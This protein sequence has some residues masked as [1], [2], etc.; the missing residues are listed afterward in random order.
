[1]WQQPQSVIKALDDHYFDY[2]GI[3]PW[4]PPITPTQITR[5]GGTTVGRTV[6]PT[7]ATTLTRLGTTRPRRTTIG[8]TTGTTFTTKVTKT[9]AGRLIIITDLHGDMPVFERTLELVAFKKGTLLGPNDLVIFT[10]DMVDRGPDAR[11]IYQ[12]LKSLKNKYK[13]RMTILIGNHELMN[14]G[15]INANK[16]KPGMPP[17]WISDAQLDC[18]AEFEGD[19]D[20]REAEWTSN[21]EIGKFVRTWDAIKI[22]ELPGQPE[23]RPLVMHGGLP[24]SMF[25]EYGGDE[26]AIKKLNDA[27]TA[28]LRK[29]KKGEAVDAN[30]KLFSSSNTSLQWYRGHANGKDATTCPEI[31]EILRATNTRR[32]IVGHTPQT[33]GVT[34]R[35]NNTLILA[36]TG[37]SLGFHGGKI[38]GPASAIS[39]EVEKGEYARTVALSGKAQPGGDGFKHYEA[40]KSYVIDSVAGR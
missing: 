22:V 39:I 8:R 15:G 34:P 12:K 7:R 33:A 10:G 17:S 35:C 19:W 40:G 9:T 16:P 5:T 4:A 27:Y 24:M 31:E 23:T 18:D 30:S 2:Y 6:V 3:K 28:V 32:M 13:E 11:K 1:V 37:M 38:S 14:I 29:D 21:G 20:K 36:D 25:Q 26:A